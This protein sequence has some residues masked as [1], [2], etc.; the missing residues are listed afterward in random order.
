MTQVQYCGIIKL[1]GGGCME[2]IKAL[3]KEINRGESGNLELESLGTDWK[4]YFETDKSRTSV[5][6]YDTEDLSTQAVVVVSPRGLTEKKLG[7]M[8]KDFSKL[9]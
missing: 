1:Q 7:N 5:Q 4:I 3:V 8:L 6:I 2:N 9:I